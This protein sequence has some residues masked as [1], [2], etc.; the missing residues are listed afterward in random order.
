MSK[1]RIKVEYPGERIDKELDSRIKTAA[2]PGVWWA[3]GYDFGTSMRDI[4]F[5]YK[6]DKARKQAVSKIIKIKGT[7]VT[8]WAN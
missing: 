4:C 6:S 2:M 7:Q 5:Y 3:Q 1:V 8:L